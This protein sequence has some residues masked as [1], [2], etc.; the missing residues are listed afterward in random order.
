MEAMRIVRAVMIAAIPIALVGCLS[1]GNR[2]RWLDPIPLLGGTT[3]PD[4]ALLQ[5]VIIERTAGTDDINRRAWDRV[6]EQVLS[7]ETRSALE[8]AGLRAGT[9]TE[10]APGVLRKLIDDPRTS[11]GHRAR[12]FALDK[13][14]P[15]P[16]S[17]II[18]RAEFSMP[19][20]NGGTIPFNREGA[21]LGFDIT[22]RRGND[23][24]VLCKVVPRAKY[25]DPSQI[26]PADAGDRGL[27][28]QNFPAAGFEL[29]LLPSE[30]IV[31]GT[32]SYWEGSFGHA[33][34]ISEKDERQA[35][36]ML[37]LKAMRSKADGQSPLVIP[38]SD[39]QVEA[40]PLAVQAAATRGIR[41]RTVACGKLSLTP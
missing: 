29:A 40:P 16:V 11:W 2:P 39:E 8:A 5:Y 30:F 38:D 26:L 9:T 22:V 7:Y 41:P 15:L 1:D 17:G 35:Q 33:A 24:K 19:T 21:V 25:H 12:T 4:T 31:I 6:D 13:P 18:E 34:F 23:G 20:A 32:D 3:D 28:T 10:S 14:A 36:R 37:V 27:S